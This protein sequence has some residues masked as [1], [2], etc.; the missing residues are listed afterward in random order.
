LNYFCT[1]F[2]LEPLVELIALII[3]DPSIR[4]D[5]LISVVLLNRDESRKRRGKGCGLS[6]TQSPIGDEGCELS[7]NLGQPPPPPGLGTQVI[8]SGL[9]GL[10]SQSHGIITSASADCT[11]NIHIETETDPNIPIIEVTKI[12]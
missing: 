5:I 9:S 1:I 12:D 4:G 2:V 6:A 7:I 11:G 8:S 3:T 10:G